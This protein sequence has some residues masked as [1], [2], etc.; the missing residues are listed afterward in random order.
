MMPGLDGFA[1][2]EQ[3]KSDVTSKA[4]RVIAMTG[5][6][7]HENVQRIMDAG[8]ERCIAQTVRQ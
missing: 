5:Y 3:V 4:T 2:C 1:V 8:A 6:Y 7:N